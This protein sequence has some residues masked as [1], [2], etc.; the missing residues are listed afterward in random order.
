[1]MILSLFTI[2]GAGHLRAQVTEVSTLSD[3]KSALA[4][5]GS[6]KLMND[7]T[8]VSEILVIDKNTN[9]DG[10]GK[11]I[12]SSAQKVLTI[13]Q[14]NVEVTISGLTL[15]SNATMNTNEGNRGFN[16]EPS[17]NNV[18]LTLDNC[19]VYFNDNIE[20]DW[21]YAVNGAGKQSSGRNITING[22]IYEGANVINMW[23]ETHTVIIDGATLNCKYKKNPVYCGACVRLDVSAEDDQ[24]T[25]KN[26]TFNGD[27]AIAIS[28]VND[29][30]EPVL[31]NNT[32]NTKY[33]V[34][35]I[36]ENYYY[37]LSKA[38]E[39]A[40][41]GQTIT[42]IQDVTLTELVAINNK[43][44]LDLNKKT[45]TANCKKAF[46]VYANATIKNGTIWSEQ[47]CVDTRKAVEL[48]LKDL[49]LEATTYYS[50]HGNQQPLTIGGS[51]NGTIVNMT[52]VDIYA[53]DPNQNPHN[54]QG[55]GIISFVKSTVNVD[56]CDILGYMAIYVKE[57]SDESVFNITNSTLTTDITGND[58]VG[59]T[60]SVIVIDKLARDVSINLTNSSLVKAIGDNMYVIGVYGGTNNEVNIGAG[61]NIDAADGNILHE[62]CVFEGNTILLPAEYADALR[63]Q[64]YIVEVVDGQVKVTGVYEPEAVI[65]IDSYQTIE[66]AVEAAIAGQTITLLKDAE[67][68]IEAGLL[69]NKSLTV[70][71]NNKSI[72]N[73]C[74]DGEGDVF[75]VE[76]VNGSTTFTV[77]NGT[78]NSEDIAIYSAGNG[79]DLNKVI[80]ENVEINSD[81]FGIYHNGSKY[82]ADITVTNSTIIDTYD[83]SDEDGVGIYLSGSQ[84]WSN[85]KD[86]AKLNVLKVENSTIKGATAVEVKYGNITIVDSKLI[87]TVTTQSVQDNGNGNCTKGYALALTN[88]TKDDKETTTVGSINLNG[89]NTLEGGVIVKAEAGVDVT[90]NSADLIPAP[91]GYYWNEEG[92][93][94][95]V[96]NST[97]EAIIGTTYY[98][99]LEDAIEE[100]KENDEIVILKNVTIEKTIDVPHHLTFNGNSHTLSYTG[101]GTTGRVFDVKNETNGANLTINNLKIEFTTDYSERGINYNTNGTLTLNNV[102]VNADQKKVT[103]A[104]NLPGLSDDATVVINNSDIT[105]LIALNI[106]GERSDIT[107]NNSDFLS[108]DYSSDENYAAISLNN[109]GNI[110]AQNSSFVTVNGGR[111]IAYDE[112][113]KPSIAILNAVA[114]ANLEIDE[115]TYIVGEMI[116]PVA[117]VY[118]SNTDNVYSCLTLKDAVDEA[119]KSNAAGVRLLESTQGSGIVINK[120]ITI[121]FNGNTYTFTEPAVG[122]QGTQTMGF[123][124]LKDNNVTLKNGSLNVSDQGDNEHAFAMLIQN[125]ANLTIEDM[126]LDGEY[127]DRYKIKDYNYSYV[128]SIN[129]GEVEIKG[130]T[131]IHANPGDEGENHYGVALDVCKYANYEAPVVTVNTTGTIEGVV[132][133]SAKLNLEAIGSKI[134]NIVI[135][136]EGQ[137]YHNVEGI[138]GTIQ[139]TFENDNDGNAEN[140][141]YTFASPFTTHSVDSLQ[142]ESDYALY[143]YNEAGA[144]WENVKDSAN[145]ESFKTLDLGRGYI[146]ANAATTEVEFNG[147]F[148]VNDVT[149]NLTARSETNLKG[150]HLVGNPFAHEITMEHFTTEAT[151]AEGVYVLENDGAWKA[152]TKGTIS[153]AQAV[154]IKTTEEKELIIVKEVN[155]KSRSIN[156]GQLMINVANSKYNDVAYVSFNEGV[157]L[158]KIA[159]RNA[160]IPMVYVPVNGTDYAVAVMNKEVAEIPVSFVANSL[161]QYTFS[162]EAQDCEFS[163][164]YLYDR[165]TGETTNLLLEDYTFM[166]KSGDNAERFIIKLAFADDNAEGIEN[167]AL[168]YNDELIINNIEGEG[169]VRIYDVLGRPVA[170][171]NVFGSANIST[172]TLRSGVYMIQMN[173]NNGVKVQ[174]VIVD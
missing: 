83:E 85:A 135:S 94:T 149:Y 125:Y 66:L 24:L 116:S 48:T 165:F 9:L 13:T 17:A 86:G 12:A 22:G 129:C 51:D 92:V 145:G 112:E 144:L 46:E 123:Q 56:N 32:D 80:V 93:L 71:L 5:G 88:N 47:R 118:Y 10:N 134:S 170:E 166:A 107:A 38:V 140:D 174:K 37:S 64:G 8:G 57:G 27:N 163:R 16:I 105:G 151:L 100:A 164:M 58:V 160:E 65:G 168:I 122:S 87:A 103:Y 130:K 54:Y 117:V 152:N 101:S 7:I 62:S 119:I 28:S 77:K 106:W 75:R 84:E 43:I 49:S 25:V 90:T 99:T 68:E 39:A 4:N 169:V 127:L 114:V 109:D 76:S 2:M 11:T 95:Q 173:D 97:A 138:K 136:G 159:H 72:T 150:F 98:D 113:G 18:K 146:Y 96:T 81:Y 111:I 70:N 1:M 157:G 115:D 120:S 50:A 141:W 108:V 29:A 102:I 21:A 30:V 171:Y 89:D 6:I 172:T 41:A 148:N 153:P 143:R 158:D 15:E 52:N 74:S 19:N 45:V 61:C 126:N 20:H 23:G 44:T 36:G 59:N 110:S 3:L 147:E 137:L 53:G 33:Y 142:T 161:G 55:Y 132:E 91:E 63:A 121:D 82:G 35:R 155:S 42:L 67:I 167:F 79:N 104:I 154:L 133:V 26:T 156:N 162:V 69:I 139:K 60:T 131:D 40:T 73:T 128:L 34:A 31:E 14:S 124:I 78:L